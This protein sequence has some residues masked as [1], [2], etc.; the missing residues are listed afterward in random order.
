MIYNESVVGEHPARDGYRL[1]FFVEGNVELGFQSGSGSFDVEFPDFKVTGLNLYGEDQLR[2]PTGLGRQV[3]DD[4][5][6]L[7]NQI[8][9]ECFFSGEYDQ[10]G[11][12][13]IKE[14]VIFTGANASF[15]ADTLDNTN[16]IA[17]SSL[18]LF[19]PPSSEDADRVFFNLPITAEQIDNRTGENIFY[20]A[21]GKDYL[22]QR[23]ISPSV[24]GKMFG[25]FAENTLINTDVYRISRNSIRDI[26][27]TSSSQVDIFTGSNIIIDGDIILD[28][29]ARLRLRTDDAVTISGDEGAVLISSDT[30]NFPVTDNAI[31]ISGIFSEFGVS[32]LLDADGATREGFLLRFNN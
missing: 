24:G 7:E 10:S 11:V 18:Q 21:I 15:N 20:R 30:T 3:S 5:L 31:Y 17:S 23:N 12:R 2:L 13:N 32:S 25:G 26:E 22:T 14:L 16:A 28:F 4:F 29:S 19:E 8:N 27:F 1:E 6:L 9:L